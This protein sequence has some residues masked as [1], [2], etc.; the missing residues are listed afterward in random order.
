MN[1]SVCVYLA[2]NFR[3][4]F[5]REASNYD[6]RIQVLAEYREQKTEEREEAE[7]AAEII[8]FLL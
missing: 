4:Y 2:E 8:R 3:R 5:I 7:K 6:S 1:F